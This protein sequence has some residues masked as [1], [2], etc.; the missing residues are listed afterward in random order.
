MTMNT[1]KTVIATM[2]AAVAAAPLAL[3]PMQ[4]QAQAAPYP[5]AAPAAYVY[6]QAELDQMLA[7]IALYPDALLSQILMA[8][9]YP[10]EVSEAARWCRANP[11]L[12]GDDAVRA[13]QNEDWDPSV[14]SLV[15]FPELLQRMDEKREWTRTLGDAFLAQETQMMDEVQR[16]RHRAQAAGSLRSDER[17]VVRERGPVIVL[18]PYAPEYIYVPYYDPLV[19]Y[20][21]WWY[22][23]YLPVAWS[24]WP[25]YV[26]PYYGPGIS[27]GF[28]WGSP[29]GVSLGFFFGDF[30]WNRRYVRVAYSNSYYYR[31]PTYANRYFAGSG[32]RWYHDSFHRRGVDYR[33]T[34]VRQRYANEAYVMGQHSSQTSRFAPQTRQSTQGSAPQTRQS[35]QTFTPQTRQSSVI[36]QPPPASAERQ[37]QREARR[38]SLQPQ[39]QPQVRQAPQSNILG[40]RPSEQR[41]QRQEQRLERR[42]TRA[43]APQPQF[44]PQRAPQPQVQR[45][46]QPQF[47]RAAP[48][49]PQGGGY[50]L[51][52]HQRE[53]RAAMPPAVAQQAPRAA[54]RQ[55]ARQ[56]RRE[57]RGPQQQAHGGGHI[58]GQ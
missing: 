52:Q 58:L 14:K 47:Q 1:R 40:Q 15:A 38:Q 24:P 30:D 45:A 44:Q 29:V 32:D 3:A 36:G 51:G 20:G 26:R 57:S 21:P 16:L 23:D 25:G 33:N 55:E 28:W 2:L 48:Q 11:G 8:A 42:E 22:P 34:A 50:A 13:V 37:A 5:Q 39:S 10:I 18:E 19:V 7:P 53:Q 17:I 6:S 49:A 31:Q 35:T 46:P 43:A 27:V 56:E 12:T 41:F 9:T 4:A 54:M